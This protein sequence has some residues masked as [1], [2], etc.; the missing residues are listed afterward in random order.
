MVDRSSA[1]AERRVPWNKEQVLR[2]AIDLADH[3]GVESLSMRKLSQALGG[4][5]MSLYNHVAD[6]DD[7]LDG[8]ID[9]LFHEIDHPGGRDWKA[10]MRQRAIS[11]RTVINRHAWAI[12]LMGRRTPGPATLRH[13]DAVIGCLRDAGFPN[14]LVAHAISALDGYIYGFALQERNLAFGTPEETAVLAEAFLQQFPSEDFPHLAAFTL[15]HVLQPGY[16]YGQ[17]YEFGLDLILDGL[18]RAHQE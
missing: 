10:A 17:E 2:A 6:K 11:V 1:S 13:H 8:M 14:Q 7:L 16:D 12:G 18:D 9:E 15:E 3:G 5:P 4:A